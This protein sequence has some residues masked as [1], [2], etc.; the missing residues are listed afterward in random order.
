MGS[1]QTKHTFTTTSPSPKQEYTQVTKFTSEDSTYGDDFNHQRHSML[2]NWKKKY[3]WFET[4]TSKVFR[5]NKN[6]TPHSAPLG[7]GYIFIF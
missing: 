6:F 7:G 3:I 1:K 2:K 5:A 4:I